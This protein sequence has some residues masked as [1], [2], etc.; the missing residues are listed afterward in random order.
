MDAREPLRDTSTSSA[1]AGAARKR[2][3]AR[4]KQAEYAS[5]R[6]DAVGL[7]QRIKLCGYVSYPVYSGRFPGQPEGEDGA[8]ARL[9]LDG[10]VA[11]HHTGQA[12]G[13]GESEA[14]TAMG[15]GVAGGALDE[16]LEDAFELVRADA[17]SGISYVDARPVLSWARRRL[18][19]FAAATDDADGAAGLG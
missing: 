15:A 18:A 5:S 1:A 9:G 3:P 14:G 16:G 19:A 11:A 4:Q 7:R 2:V 10:D 12:S 17:G 13:N 8:M 6:P